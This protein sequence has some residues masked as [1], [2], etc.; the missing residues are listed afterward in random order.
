LASFNLAGTCCCPRNLA[1]TRRG[2]RG[3]SGERILHLF[4]RPPKKT[5]AVAG[6]GARAEWC[7]N[8]WRPRTDPRV[9]GAGA[10]PHL[11]AG[12]IAREGRNR[13]P[14]RAPAGTSP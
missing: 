1:G 7:R 2:M 11:R 12:S 5:S 10:A 14:R 4:L 3:R 9:D 13:P 6:L 8:G